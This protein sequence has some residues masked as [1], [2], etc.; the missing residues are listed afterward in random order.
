MYSAFVFSLFS[1]CLQRIDRAYVLGIS[2]GN[3]W[4]R[5]FEG[6]RLQGFIDGEMEGVMSWY[7]R[8]VKM[9]GGRGRVLMSW[10]TKVG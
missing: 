3:G 4:Q 5:L 9:D 2:G 7:R 6:T 10:Q 8:L 1:Q